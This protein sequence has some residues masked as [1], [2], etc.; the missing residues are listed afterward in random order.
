MW[1]SNSEE[2]GVIDTM[3]YY[4]DCS[5]TDTLL[6]LFSMGFLKNN[7]VWGHYA[8]PSNFGVC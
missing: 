8:P 4:P 3:G 2:P 6:T 1:I 7:T 5:T